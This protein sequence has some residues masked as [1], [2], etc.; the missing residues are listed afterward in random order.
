MAISSGAA[1]PITATEPLDD[2]I[3]RRVAPIFLLTRS[4]VQTDLKLVPEQIADANQLSAELHVKA[5]A[6][7]GLVGD[8]NVAAVKAAR[9]VIDDQ[10]QDWLSKRLSPE[11][12]DRLGQLDLQWEGAAAM[13]TR[14]LVTEYLDLTP[15]QVERIGGFVMVARRRQSQATWNAGDHFNLT[16]QAIAVLSN[17]QRER[18]INLLG[19]KC[20]FAVAAVPA[21]SIPSPRTA[22]A[23]AG[24]NFPAR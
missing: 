24:P 7:R 10:Q 2:R 17:S 1:R 16:R 22:R 14:P 11:Q 15:A 23:G 18:W 4:D 13:I 20:E 12:L 9:K 21:A 6:L 3:G 8:K 19:P 5:Q